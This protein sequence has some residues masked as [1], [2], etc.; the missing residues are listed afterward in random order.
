MSLPY[1]LS[2]TR[3][4]T[5]TYTS[6]VQDRNEIVMRYPRTSIREGENFTVILSTANFVDLRSVKLIAELDLKDD[7]GA[8]V[9]NDCFMPFLF[10]TITLKT[11]QG[12]IIEHLDRAKMTGYLK[13]IF[14]KEDDDLETASSQTLNNPTF[15]IRDNDSKV[16]IPS[17][18][19]MGFFNMNKVLRLST[20]GALVVD[21][22]LSTA[23]NCYIYRNISTAADGTHTFKL[24][25]LEVVYDEVDVTPSYLNMYNETIERTGMNLQFMSVA[26]SNDVI[27]GIIGEKQVPIHK[28][29]QNCRNLITTVTELSPYYDQ[30]NLVIGSNNMYAP[31][32]D[33]FFFQYKLGGAQYPKGG[34]RNSVMAYKNFQDCTLNNVKRKKTNE[35][36]KQN[37]THNMHQTLTMIPDSTNFTTAF[38]EYITFNYDAT[39]AFVVKAKQKAG[40]DKLLFDTYLLHDLLGMRFTTLKYEV[41]KFTGADKVP[42]NWIKVRINNAEAVI[43]KEGTHIVVRFNETHTITNMFMHLYIVLGSTSRESAGQPL[44]FD[45]EPVEKYNGSFMMC[46]SLNSVLSPESSNYGVVDASS[47]YLN[48]NFGSAY[49]NHGSTYEGRKNAMLSVDTYMFHL[50]NVLVRDGSVSVSL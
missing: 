19:L 39:N 23:R 50:K 27:E 26:H 16:V 33:E 1:Q 22:Q 15:Q 25:N 37:F 24:K 13:Q 7:T 30:N 20:F 18:D 21:F 45:F 8:D 47:A 40:T 49:E 34:V 38:S 44:I 10:E 14:T 9:S 29:I 32:T 43:K 36:T 35:I 48:F 17:F 12:V 28:S 31:N 42:S 46:Y 4:A 6:V 41:D 2:Y 5:N 3:D 11:E